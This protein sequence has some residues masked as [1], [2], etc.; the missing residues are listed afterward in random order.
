MNPRGIVEFIVYTLGF[1]AV[2]ML[3]MQVASNLQCGCKQLFF[4][5]AMKILDILLNRIIKSL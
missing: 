3:I 1:L 4:T 2:V 5:M